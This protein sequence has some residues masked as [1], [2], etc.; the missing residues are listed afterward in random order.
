M[1][2]EMDAPSDRAWRKP[3]SLDKAMEWLLYRKSPQQ[4][5]IYTSPSPRPRPGRRREKNLLAKT[6]TGNQCWIIV[7]LIL[8]MLCANAEAL[9]RRKEY[10]RFV[11]HEEIVFDRSQPPRLELLRR[12]DKADPLAKAKAIPSSSST[13]LGAMTTAPMRA[14]FSSAATAVASS[15]TGD[16][17]I[18]IPKGAATGSASAAASSSAA[19]T[20]ILSAPAGSSSLPKAFDGGIGKNFTQSTCPLFLNSFLNNE[21]FTQCMPFSLF[22]QVGQFPGYYLADSS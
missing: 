3:R 18:V 9:S 17:S 22:L 13:G 8:S 19:A 20:S 14:H 2:E 4:I 10:G 16:L 15:A 21:T 6:M 12:A 5:T 7:T 11:R 1:T